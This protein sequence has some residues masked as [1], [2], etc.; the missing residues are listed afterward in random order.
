MIEAKATVL[1][2]S[3]D[4]SVQITNMQFVLCLLQPCVPF[5]TTVWQENVCAHFGI[6]TFFAFITMY[7]EN[8]A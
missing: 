6:P 8:M 3:T 5:S 1:L 4:Q 7:L 2:Q